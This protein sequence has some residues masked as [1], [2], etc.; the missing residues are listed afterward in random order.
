[1]LGA[2]CYAGGLPHPQGEVLLSVGTAQ[3]SA[4]HLKDDL[5]T[6]GYSS[7]QL[8]D[9]KR[10]TSWALGYRQPLNERW[11]VEAQYLD[12]GKSKPSL[13]A[14]FPAGKTDAQAAQDIAQ[15]RPERGQG[16]TVAGVYQQPLGKRWLAQVGGGAFAWRSKNEATVGNVRYTAKDTGISPLVQVGLGYK[17]TP[18][19][20][21]ETTAQHFFMP[22]E[23]VDRVAV[24]VAMGF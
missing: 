16:L 24:G 7:V 18:K 3:Q 23:D 6:Q 20:T 14:T 2:T 1:M 17:V 13:A 19:V 12:Q 10:A 11:C 5:Q 21:L 4:S 8:Q 15:A 22:H 9:D